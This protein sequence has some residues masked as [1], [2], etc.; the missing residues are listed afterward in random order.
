MYLH[1]RDEGRIQ[2]VR[3]CLLCVQDLHRVGSTRYGEDGGLEEVLRELH[4]V[5]GGRGHDKL[6]IWSFLHH[7][8]QSPSY[9]NQGKSVV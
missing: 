4:G 2:V 1:D 5:Q 6:H 8:L 9:Q 3:L 7:L